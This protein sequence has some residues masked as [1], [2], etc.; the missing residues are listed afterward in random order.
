MAVE[1]M[2]GFGRRGNDPRP[3]K[4]ELALSVGVIGHR[5]NKLPAG[6]EEALAA[7]IQP[8]LQAIVRELDR[9]RTTYRSHFDGGI[10]LT[11]LSSLAEGADRA[12]A[13]ALLTCSSA[14]GAP[15]HVSYRLDTPLPFT[16]AEY[17][18]DFATDASKADFTAY[19]AAASVVLE[20]PGRR[21]REDVAYEVAALT[22]V[23][24][25][26]LL[27]A[28]WD[29]KPAAGRGG[30]AE[31]VATAAQRG[32][33]VVIVDPAGETP[34]RLYW[35]NEAAPK[36]LQAE[37]GDTSPANPML[38]LP[39]LID[40]VVRPPVHAPHVG[41]HR[42]PQELR[43][44]FAERPR[45]FNLNL[46]YPML[47]WLAGRRF[48][49]TDF[50]PPKAEQLADGFR[51]L[52]GTFR[53]FA[54]EIL[55]RA[56]GWADF[57]GT[58]YARAFRSAFI[59]NFTL[60]ALAVLFAALTLVLPD[61]RLPLNL[62]EIVFIGLIVANT[63]WGRSS[64]WQTRWM[65]GR[66]IAERLRVAL[67]QWAAGV[68]PRSL[69]TGEEPTWTGWYAR[70][71][72]RSLGMRSGSLDG[73]GLDDAA[74]LLDAVIA[75]QLNYHRNNVRLSEVVEKRLELIG[76]ACF[77]LT[78]VAAVLEVALHA[79]GV[80]PS[81]P[82]GGLLTLATTAFPAIATASYGMRLI[83]DFAGLARQ[84]HTTAVDLERLSKRVEE[85]RRSG[86]SLDQ[87]RGL[88][89]A[90]AAVMLG[91]IATWRLA[92]ESR[93]LAIPG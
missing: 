50:F 45:R 58:R 47:Q 7:V 85:A 76:S 3:P 59:R 32:L 2:R 43:K 12:G 36:A 62:C 56:Y 1:L 52:P 60:G 15:P 22:L 90:A 48:R 79:F 89:D 23:A 35:W 92:A 8:I 93:A 78:L 91:H 74:A 87:V 53:I 25:C 28:V 88:A 31:T 10:T 5:L 14:G 81:E 19:C 24:N 4:P 64:N 34:P 65:E 73:R 16:V 13:R 44:F 54:P 67:I 71:V 66:E 46:A 26:D 70:A 42:H 83:G 39:M 68:R 72:L 17:S 57:V 11:V 77:I 49:S 33:P 84:S 9:C 20:L 41:P 51:A 18:R 37:L 75:D 82:G 29:R 86:A 27:I 69:A 40:A 63:M 38:H 21:E 61:H 55:P 80:E 30:T 6:G